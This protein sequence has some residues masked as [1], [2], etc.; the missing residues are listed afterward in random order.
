[1]LTA[2]QRRDSLAKAGG[3]PGLRCLCC[4]ASL[5]RADE[6]VCP[7]EVLADPYILLA[8]AEMSVDFCVF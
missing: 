7:H 1:M 2:Q 4:R 3:T 5:D 6:G 8:L